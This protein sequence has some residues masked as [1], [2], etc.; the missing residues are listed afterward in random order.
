MKDFIEK[1]ICKNMVK[2]LTIYKNT[3]DHNRLEFKNYLDQ[4]IYF[5]IEEL[6]R[7]IKEKNRDEERERRTENEI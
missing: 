3:L 4:T 6:I 1:I 7:Y 5:E 2:I